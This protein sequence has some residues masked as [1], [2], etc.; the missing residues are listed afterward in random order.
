M[1]GSGRLAAVPDGARIVKSFEWPITILDGVVQQAVSTNGV[2]IVLV[3]AAQENT[4]TGNKAVGKRRPAADQT[5]FHTVP[6]LVL[7][8]A[9]AVM[10]APVVRHVCEVAVQKPGGRAQGVACIHILREFRIPQP[11]LIAQS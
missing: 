2:Q 5:T 4:V 11:P 6:Q 3:P 10:Q 1:P 9:Q 8:M 7:A